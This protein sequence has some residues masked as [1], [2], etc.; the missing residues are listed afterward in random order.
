M[1][2][3]KASSTL[4]I[5]ADPFTPAQGSKPR[6]GD[7]GWEIRRGWGAPLQAKGKVGSSQPL[8][9]VCKNPG[10]QNEEAP[11][12]ELPSPRS[13]APRS[14][15]ALRLRK[16]GS[17]S[18]PGQSPPRCG[19]GVPTSPARQLG[20]SWAPLTLR[21][22]GDV[23]EGQREPPAAGKVVRRGRNLREGAGQEQGQ[24]PRQ[25]GHN[26]VEPPDTD[27]GG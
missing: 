18:L 12:P 9:I 3:L 7:Q 5:Q 15:A 8:T 26:G 24:D 2:S 11:G 6:L 16:G 19:T 27:G 21:A 23:F 25:R 22:R 17:G 13:A 4:W 14:G 10:I 1:Q 20:L